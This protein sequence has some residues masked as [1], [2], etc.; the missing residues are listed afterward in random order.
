MV[1]QTWYFKLNQILHK[2]IYVLICPYQVSLD[3]LSLL[4]IYN[5][6]NL[7]FKFTLV[8]RILEIILNIGVLNYLGL[9]LLELRLSVFTVLFLVK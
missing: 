1:L 6:L 4:H 3:T 7:I 9:L 8:N 2:F 5:L